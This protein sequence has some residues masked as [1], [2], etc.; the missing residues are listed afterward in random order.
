MYNNFNF[1]EQPFRVASL[2]L[3]QTGKQGESLALHLKV[4]RFF[5]V[6]ILHYLT[7]IFHTGSTL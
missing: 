1:A 7:D 3:I 6:E 5:E 4:E 2:T